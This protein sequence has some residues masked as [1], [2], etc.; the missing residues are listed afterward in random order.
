MIP[1]P[2]RPA[3]MRVIAPDLPGYGKSDKPAAREDYSY[4]R[5]VEWMG[6]WLEKNDFSNITFFWPGLGRADWAAPGGQSRR[7]V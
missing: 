1:Y 6:N 5:Q 7:S 3:G 4:E 2:Y